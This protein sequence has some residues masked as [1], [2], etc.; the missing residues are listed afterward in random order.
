MAFNSVRNYLLEQRTRQLHETREFQKNDRN[1]QL[2]LQRNPDSDLRRMYDS[3]R[4]RL[5]EEQKKYALQSE[6]DKI[7]QSFHLKNL[8]KKEPFQYFDATPF[9]GYPPNRLPAP[10]II[11]VYH[12]FHTGQT[13]TITD[14]ISETGE[15]LHPILETLIQT[16]YPQYMKYVDKYC[17]PLGS[18]DATFADFNREQVKSK[19]IPYERQRK[20]ISHATRILDISPYLPVHFVDTSYAKLPLNTGT[21]YHNRHSFK[22]N[23]HA[24]F[25]APD[26]YRPRPT[27]KGYYVN[28]FLESARTLVHY[29]KQYGMP[30]ETTETPTNEDI[31]QYALRMNKFFLEYPTLLFTRSHISDRDMNLKCRPVYA[32]DD[33]FLKIEA[34]L[35]FPLHIMARSY[36]SAIMYGLETIRGGLHH[37]DHLAKAYK[38]YASLDW[39]QFDQRAPFCLVTLFFQTIRE[40]IIVSNGYHP[41]YEYP[42]YPDLNTEKMAL[43][44][45]NLTTFLEQWYYN[46][47]F[48]TADGYAY[49]RSVAGVPS[50]LLNTQFLDSFINI[51]SIIDAMLEYGFSD[52][53]IESFRF[54]IMGDDNTF[55]C[56]LPINELNM[57]VT[58]FANYALERYNMKL[59]AEKS[60]VTCLRNHISV[61]SYTSNFG[62]P[63]RPIGKLV[64]QLCYPEHGTNLKYM[65]ARAIGIAYAACAMDFMFHS[66]CKDVYYSFLPYAA[67]YTKADIENILKHLPGQFKMLDAYVETINLN[68]F[69]GFHEIRALVQQWQ[70][71]LSEYPK[72]DSAHFINEARHKPEQFE[73]LHQYNTRFKTIQFP[74]N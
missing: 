6:Y 5:T 57:F 49:K 36:D 53:Q 25:S 56:D 31:I 62:M 58:W 22:I 70:G 71:P 40:N 59:N 52:H 11:P 4:D 1:K 66:F 30:F 43:R 63:I 12:K 72:W 64:A 19:P 48:V 24:K 32:V 34:M 21:G 33:L 38:S 23:A 27:S 29:I 2:I 15:R 47:T 14:F 55:F 46:M 54:F 42:S 17:R 68:Y 50:G 8:D 35:T 13:V 45:N 44:L 7:L 10:G 69:P 73:T 60:T 74:E 28:A 41:T 20:I 67:E 37:L 65:S 51:S 9:P 18:T 26:E 61:L 16:K 3:Q 39:S